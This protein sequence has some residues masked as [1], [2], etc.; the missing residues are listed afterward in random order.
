MIRFLRL[1][2]NE[3]MKIWRR[4]STP[5]MCGILAAACILMAFVMKA[6]QPAEAPADPWKQSLLLE[7]EQLAES[8]SKG[9][10][11]PAM[12]EETRKKM[13]INE[14]RLQKNLPPHEPLMWKFTRETGTLL[15]PL[16]TLFTVITGATAVAGEFSMGTIKFLLI[17]PPGRSQILLAKYLSILLFALGLL[18][19]LFVLLPLVGGVMFGFESWGPPRLIH[20]G[21]QIIERSVPAHLLILFAGSTAELLMMV[22]FAFMISTVFRSS[23]AA[24]GLSVFLMFAG[25]QAVNILSLRG[26]DWIRW[27]L[28]ANTDLLPYFGEGSPPAEGMTL[29]F[30]LTV[31]VVHFL[32]FTG[33]SW[34]V[35]ARR[36]VA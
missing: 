11:P 8:L 24:I 2:Q 6:Y 31:L 29:A 28:F 10:L 20:D 19:L 14:Y 27:I 4:L 32:L 9:Q 22:T 13:E 1:V 21:Q 30:S 12:A 15:I 25:H 16:V 18:L 34:W 5:V 3:N 33:I 23:S 7:N 35:F 17:R 36:D 26:A